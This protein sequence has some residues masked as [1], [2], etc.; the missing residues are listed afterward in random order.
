MRNWDCE[1]S[2]DFGPCEAHCIVHAQREGAA[3]RTADELAYVFIADMIDIAAATDG[4]YGGELGAWGADVYARAGAALADGGW[5]GDDGTL[6]DEL[7]DL[8]TQIESQTGL[9]V[10]WDDGF[11]A[12]Q[13]TGGPLFDGDDDASDESGE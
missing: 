12:A 2:E 7:H 3:V 5:I 13:V 1:C 11:I 10:T 8:V 6:A 4:K 9:W